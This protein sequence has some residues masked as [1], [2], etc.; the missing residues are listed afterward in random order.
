MATRAQTRSSSYDGGMFD[1][2]S[3]GLRLIAEERIASNVINI[4][5]VVERIVEYLR[6]NGHAT[7]REEDIDLALREGIVKLSRIALTDPQHARFT[8]GLEPIIL[9][10]DRPSF[11]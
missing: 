7:G 8:T 10:V 4:G 11:R 3:D 6:E 5:P 1:L 2:E 9:G